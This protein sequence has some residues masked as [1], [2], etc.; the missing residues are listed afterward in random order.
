MIVGAEVVEVH[1]TPDVQAK[2][3]QMARETGRPSEELLE[4]ALRGLFDEMAHAREML[5]KV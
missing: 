1:F 5:E 3:D 4:D 2:L